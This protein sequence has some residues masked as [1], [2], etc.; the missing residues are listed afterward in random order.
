MPLKDAT[1]PIAILFTGEQKAWLRKEAAQ[2]DRPIGWIVRRLVE[3]A[4]LAA[5]PSDPEPSHFI[6]RSAHR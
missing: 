5:A 3:E 4:R 6:Q 2:L 1:N